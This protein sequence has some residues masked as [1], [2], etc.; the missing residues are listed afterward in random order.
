VNF[1]TLAA[2]V[3]ISSGIAWDF[4]MGFQPIPIPD[5]AVVANLLDNFQR[6]RSVRGRAATFKP[7]FRKRAYYP[8]T[9]GRGCLFSIF[10]TLSPT[11]RRGMSTELDTT[12]GGCPRGR[13]AEESVFDWQSLPDK[14]HAES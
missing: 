10:H 3:L 2:L 9:S 13:L 1:L 12:P 4:F 14:P 6:A 5:P 8:P 7:S 11:A